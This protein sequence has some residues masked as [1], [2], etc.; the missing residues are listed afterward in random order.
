MEINTNT[1]SMHRLAVY[2][3]RLAED[4]SELLPEIKGYRYVCITFRPN[5]A[6]PMISPALI[7]ELVWKIPVL[8]MLEQ[9]Y[10]N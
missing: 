8:F 9:P 3:P 4:G 2:W 10:Q 5:T 1:V 7:L 6:A